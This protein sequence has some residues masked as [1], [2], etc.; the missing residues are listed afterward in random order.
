MDVD[1]VCDDIRFWVEKCN[2]MGVFMFF[3]SVGDVEDIVREGKF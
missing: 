1:V 2:K 3:K